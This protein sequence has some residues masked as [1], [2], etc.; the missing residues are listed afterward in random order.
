MGILTWIVFGLVAG[1]VAK[2]I[3][4]GHQGGG[5][6]LT[7]VL[8]I[9]GAVV[10]G[11]IGTHLFSFGDVNAFDLRSMAIAVGGALVVLFLYGMFNR[12]RSG[13]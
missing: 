4:P 2:F 10:G 1:M 12:N 8:G 7:V 11:F 9:I 3:M 6:I 13:Y 5:I